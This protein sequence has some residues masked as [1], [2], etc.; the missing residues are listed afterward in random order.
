M[1]KTTVN[2]LS[3][4][5]YYFH[6]G[7]KLIELQAKQWKITFSIFDNFVKMVFIKNVFTYGTVEP[8]L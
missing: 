4:E 5:A 1:L 6:V 8:K 7:Q 3:F 2:F